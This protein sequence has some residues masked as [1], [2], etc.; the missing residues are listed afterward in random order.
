VSL[1]TFLSEA[2]AAEAQ[3]ALSYLVCSSTCFERILR[4]GING[5]VVNHG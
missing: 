1:S 4:T 3:L 2:T 5:S